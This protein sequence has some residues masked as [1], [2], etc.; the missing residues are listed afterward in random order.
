MTESAETTNNE[1]ALEGVKPSSAK[2]VADRPAE[3]APP[4][5]VVG[6]HAWRRYFARVI[7]NMINGGV[8]IFIFGFVLAMIDLQAAERFFRIF[9]VKG[10]IVLDAMFTVFVALFANALLIGLCGTSL[11]K[12]IMGI[13]VC[14]SEGRT[15]GAARG[16]KR[17]FLVWFRGLAIGVPILN[18][19]AMVM[20]YNRYTTSG[21]T[22]WDK[23]MDTRVLFR[24]ETALQHVLTIFGILLWAALLIGSRLLAMA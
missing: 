14:D 11:G 12:L 19:I 18:L 16:F 3:N 23:D 20:A 10:G 13:Y 22:S 1:S 2:W 5:Y 4:G 24:R 9:E 8:C 7:D 21:V 17:E 15:I 6:V